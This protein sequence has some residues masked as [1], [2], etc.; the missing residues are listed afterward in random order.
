MSE[1]KIIKHTGNA[2]KVLLRKNTP[3]KKKL[4]ELFFEILIIVI[5]V[6]ITLWFHNWNEHLHEKKLAKDFLTGISEDLKITATTID[7][8]NIHF[9]QTLDYYDTLWTQIVENRLNPA[10]ADS[11]SGNLV[12]MASFVFDG[13]RFESF[14][15]SGNLRLIEDKTLLQH[16]TKMYTVALPNRRNS[17]QLVFQERRNQYITFIGSK[18]PMGPKGNSLISG[19]LNDPAVR[20]QIMWQRN[21]LHEMTDQKVALKEE[22]KTLITEIDEELGNK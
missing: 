22:I 6:S 11:A 18:A 3:W 1:E 19:L 2:A 16:I 10:F 7:K 14:K 12:N 17:D 4:E 15:S 8:G 9:Q 13:S 5:A 21:L 20:F